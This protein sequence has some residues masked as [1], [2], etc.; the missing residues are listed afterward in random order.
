MNRPPQVRV[1]TRCLCRRPMPS[2]SQIYR[3]E[4]EAS[5]ALPKCLL[6]SQAC[7][8]HRRHCFMLRKRT[9]GLGRAPAAQMRG[10]T[11]MCTGEAA[12][13]PT[14]RCSA[15][16]RRQTA[17][18][19]CERSSQPC[20]SAPSSGMALRHFGKQQSALSMLLLARRFQS[21]QHSRRGKTRSGR[22]SGGTPSL[23]PRQGRPPRQQAARVRATLECPFLLPRGW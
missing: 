19:L 13:E 3:P 7:S 22:G 14:L 16:P 4:G 2:L 11:S 6:L 12:A 10:A 23:P 21:P 9:A 20:L 18:S 17:A 1:L 5:C 8:G 15:P